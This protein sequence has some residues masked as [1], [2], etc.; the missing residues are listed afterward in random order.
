METDNLT[1]EAA[2]VELQSIM[3]ALQQEQ[4]SIDD[5]GDKSER[6][7][8]LI[9][10]CQHKLRDLDAKLETMADKQDQ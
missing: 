9:Q 1:Y 4:V 8:Q 6:A 5:L 10:Y 2:L 7:R 3:D